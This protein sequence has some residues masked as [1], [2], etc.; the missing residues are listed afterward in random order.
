[1]PSVNSG[2]AVVQ[3]DNPTAVLVINPPGVAATVPT[4]TGPASSPTWQAG[5]AAA[6]SGSVQFNNGGSFSGSANLTYDD[7]NRIITIGNA[8]SGTIAAPQGTASAAGATLF[9]RG[10]AG[11]VTT[12]NGSAVQI[13]GGVATTEGTGG[14]INI[15]GSPGV[16]ASATNRAGGLVQIVAGAGVVGA[17]GG[18]LTMASGAG[19]PTGT[20]GAMTYTSGAG[21]GTSGNSGAL[22]LKS[23]AA[24]VG[25]TGLVTLGSGNATTGSAGNIVV[26]RGTQGAAVAST[27]GIFFQN[28][29]GVDCVVFDALNNF[30]FDPQPAFNAASNDG[31]IWIPQGSGPP[32]GTPTQYNSDYQNSAPLY[33]DKTNF[34][35][36]AYNFAGANWKGVQFA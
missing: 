31:F 19:G 13:I 30:V 34:K 26:A 20:G 2:P 15:A 5:G 21:G 24:P 27:Q 29:Q 28:A 1:M 6:P 22:S 35:L 25:N 33:Y 32:T 23:G 3:S 14:G 4:S 10:G 36:W 11:G 8:T 17:T 9:L 16:T 7:T 18:A 12:G